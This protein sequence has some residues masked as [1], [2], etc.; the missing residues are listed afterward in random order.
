MRNW[1]R[2][3]KVSLAVAAVIPVAAGIALVVAVALQPRPT[4]EQVSDLA[5]SKRFDEA[6]TQGNSYLRLFPSDSRVLLIMAEIELSRPEPEPRRALELLERIEA[7]SSSLA[8]WVLVDRGNAY[9]ALAR[10]DQ[11]EACWT[12][13]LKRD[14]TVLEAG[15]RLLDLLGLQGRFDEARAL[16]LRQFENEPDLRDAWGCS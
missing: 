9:Y 8:A 2:I 16:A 14:P 15:R 12:E 1:L 5:R 6:L 7:D 3:R 13:A 10:F 4:F 11:S